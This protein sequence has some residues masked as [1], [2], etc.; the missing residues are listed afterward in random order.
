M[1]EIINS[2]FNRNDKDIFINNIILG[3]IP[4]GSANALCKV[5]SNYN[6]DNNDLDH[7]Y[8]HYINQ[9][10]EADDPYLIWTKRS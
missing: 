5:I 8:V 10:Q 1:H 7:I 6:D 2:I 9:N 4:G 3:V